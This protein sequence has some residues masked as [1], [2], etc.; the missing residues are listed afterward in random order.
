MIGLLNVGIG[1]KHKLGMR[2]VVKSIGISFLFLTFLLSNSR[3]IPSPLSI[4]FIHLPRSFSLPLVIQDH[5]T[6]K[7]CSDSSAP[8]CGYLAFVFGPGYTYSN[9]GCATASYELTVELLESAATLATLDDSVAGNSGGG[10]TETAEAS[11]VCDST[12]FFSSYLSFISPGP[13]LRHQ[14]NRPPYLTP[15]R[16]QQRT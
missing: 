13:V 7:K 8:A 15:P 5:D 1:L 6:N 12:I 14:T 9:F 2:L 11:V 3:L 10:S 16:S 4:N